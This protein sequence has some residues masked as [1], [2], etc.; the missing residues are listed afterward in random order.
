MDRFGAID[1]QAGG[2]IVLLGFLLLVA[3]E[4]CLVV[5]AG[6]LTVAMVGLVVQHQDVPRPAQLVQ[7]AG[8][9]RGVALR[10]ALDDATSA[11][12]VSRSIRSGSR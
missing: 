1:P 11:S 10:A 3:L 2:L 9:E 7:D 4:V 8:A 12:V 5:R 6:L